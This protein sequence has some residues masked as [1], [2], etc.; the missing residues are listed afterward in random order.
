MTASPSKPSHYLRLLKPDQAAHAAALMASMASCGV[1]HDVSPMGTGKTFVACS[2]ALAKL[3]ATADR[4]AE[5]WVVCPAC[6]SAAWQS[7][8]AA[9]AGEK[10]AR[11]AARVRVVTQ[12]HANLHKL[13]AGG[14][15]A[16]PAMIVLDEAHGAKNDSKFTRA[17]AALAK[18]W[19][20]PLLLISG[21]PMDKR[22]QAVHLIRS[23]GYPDLFTVEGGEYVPGPDMARLTAWLTEKG[24]ISRDKEMAAMD[25]LSQRQPC[26]K[27][28]LAVVEKTFHLL[29]TNRILGRTRFAMTSTVRAPQPVPLYVTPKSDGDAEEAKI[30]SDKLD[31]LRPSFEKGQPEFQ[32]GNR[33]FAKIVSALIAIESVKSEPL[34]ELLARRYAD[35]DSGDTRFVVFFQHVKPLRRVADALEANGVPASDILFVPGE[36]TPA[37]RAPMIEAFQKRDGPRFFLATHDSCSVGVSLHDVCGQRREMYLTPTYRFMIMLQSMARTN[38][39]GGLSESPLRVVYVRTADGRTAEQKM[40]ESIHRK[41]AVLE[42]ATSRRDDTQDAFRS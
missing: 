13:S 4:T 41:F 1:A 38:R 19:P 26:S 22:E 15:T 5:A 17:F 12:Y 40:I 29:F 27:E 36:K 35:P 6:V 20:V 18:R 31:S 30:A 9:I 33:D 37:R 39:H 16:P 28:K 2:I 25:A 8:L 24:I 3:A 34:G 14:R 42:Q 23:M 7:T 11:L 21:T 10:G 32:P